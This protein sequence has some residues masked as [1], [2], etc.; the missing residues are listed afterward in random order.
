MTA[1]ARRVE[2]LERPT[3]HA[4]RLIMIEGPDSCG[5]DQAVAELGI[6]TVKDDLV[7]YIC[8]PGDHVPVRFLSGRP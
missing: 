4:G 5:I 8:W 7:I 3:S 6:E 1:I 2:R